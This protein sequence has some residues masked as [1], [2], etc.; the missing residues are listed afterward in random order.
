MSRISTRFSASAG[1]REGEPFDDC[2]T[3]NVVETMKGIS[4]DS[5]PSF[6]RSSVAIGGKSCGRPFVSGHASNGLK[7]D[8]LCGLSIPPDISTLGSAG[9]RGS[10]W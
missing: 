6:T 3:R 4:C 8:S 2:S 9:W 5:T 1:L 7:G 10:G